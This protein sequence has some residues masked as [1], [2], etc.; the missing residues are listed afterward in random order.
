MNIVCPKCGA[1]NRIPD[2]PEP[3]K[4]YRCGKCR[5]G[6]TVAPEAPAAGDGTSAISQAAAEEGKRK[7]ARVAGIVL[8]CLTLVGLAALA[9]SAIAEKISLS[10]KESLEI[11]MSPNDIL[12]QTAQP[13]AVD[14]IG[15]EEQ[16]LAALMINTMEK[17]GAIG[18]SAPQVGV[19]RRISVVRLDRPSAEEQ[20]LVMVNPEITKQEG[21]VSRTE[22]C[23]SVS[24]KEWGIEIAR[25]EQVTVE[26][27]TLEGE[28]V[29]L[30]EK[31]WNA[32]IIQHEIKHLDGKLI[33]D[34]ARPFKITPEFLVAIS[35]AVV[36]LFI[37]ISF[38]LKKRGRPKAEGLE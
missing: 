10:S 14:E 8:L 21:N 27:W 22:G 31:G 9:G 2:P 5:T 29:V 38:L 16:R 11:V 7:V 25:S 26:Y 4:G 30:E 15:E 24:R 32:R 37:E 1:K 28:E 18:L 19:S 13:V 6:L 17:A 33:T 34:D 36:A 12:G 23:L 3:G 20:I 35:I